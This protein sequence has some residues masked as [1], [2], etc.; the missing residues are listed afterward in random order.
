MASSS[1]A[2]L[3]PGTRLRVE[4]LIELLKAK[5]YDARVI[6]TLRTCSEQDSLSGPKGCRS[7]HV[8]GRAADIGLYENNKILPWAYGGAVGEEEARKKTDPKY[9]DIGPIAESLG[10]VWGGRWKSSFDPIHVEYHPGLTIKEACPDP[11]QCEQLVA[12]GLPD[13]NDTT[14][15]SPVPVEE[16]ASP[17]SSRAGWMA[18]ISLAISVGAVAVAVAAHGKRHT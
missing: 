13:D 7:W 10:L 4:R 14:P 2:D 16:Q 6:S 3:T 12:K 18:F 17:S 8:W 15:P 9:L 5:G 1:T 11:K